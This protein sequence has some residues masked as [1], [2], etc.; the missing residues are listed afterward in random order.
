MVLILCDMGVRSFNLLKS[1]MDKIALV[2]LGVVIPIITIFAIV[3][4]V[5]ITKKQKEENKE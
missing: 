2:I 4:V 3:R 1:G 5:K